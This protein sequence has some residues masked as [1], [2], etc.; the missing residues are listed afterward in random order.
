MRILV[1]GAGAVGGY[2]GGRLLN[3]GRDV[4]FLVRPKRAAQLASTGLIIQSEHAPDLH[5]PSP[6]LVRSTDLHEPYDLILLSCKA[7]DLDD[8]I[9]A[10]SPA[11]GPETA[12]LPLLNGMRHLDVLDAKFHPDRVLGGR[13]FITAR[14]DDA[15]RVVH[16]GP[17]HDLA[18]GGRTEQARLRASRLTPLLAGAGFEFLASDHVLLEMWE[19]WVFLATFAGSHCLLRASSADIAASG[20][21]D[22]VVALLHECA[23]IASQNDHPA[24]PEW[25]ERSLK[26]LTSPRSTSTASMLGD[27]ERGART[28]GHHILG[29]LLDRAENPAQ[30]PLLRLA[31]AA[32][33]AHEARTAREGPLRIVP[34]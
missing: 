9:H 14:L 30:A 18:F 6:P 33:K 23:R 11:V 27:L 31:H 26:I 2:F 4:T 20:G 3:A 7:Y 32:I 19:K 34:V 25:I 24:R 12:I 16:T 29:D 8:A 10:I 22:I 5:L 1:L 13:C 28:E 15:G 17:Y 21:A